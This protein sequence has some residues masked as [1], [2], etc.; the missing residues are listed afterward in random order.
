MLL[1]EEED[2]LKRWQNNAEKEKRKVRLVLVGISGGLV[3]GI[4]I[5]VMLTSGW[6]VRANMEANTEL[7]PFTLI[8]AIIIIAVFCGFFYKKHK[9]DINEQRYKELLEKKQKELLQNDA[10]N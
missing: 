6:Y 4:A 7:D 5:I 3:V 10:A 8:V 2:F 9:F 1:K